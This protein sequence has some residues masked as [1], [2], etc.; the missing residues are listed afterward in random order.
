VISVLVHRLGRFGGLRA[1]AKAVMMVRSGRSWVSARRS[2]RVTR[3][4]AAAGSAAQ[5]TEICCR[6]QARGWEASR[7]ERRM[8]A[9][10]Q[11][12]QCDVRPTWAWTL[13]GVRSAETQTMAKMRGLWRSSVQRKRHRRHRARPAA[14][15]AQSGGCAEWAHW[16]LA[17]RALRGNLAMSACPSAATSAERTGAA[18]LRVRRVQP[19]T[20]FFQLGGFSFKD[21]HFVV[22]LPC[23]SAADM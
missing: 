11:P 14:F 8:R 17:A 1:L 16:T 21:G 22:A 20:G 2:R 15:A 5:R 9:R 12:H 3:R 7:G 6:F 18:M 23:R 13:V 19:L 4:F 10:K